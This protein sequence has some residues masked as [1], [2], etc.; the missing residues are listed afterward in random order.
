[1]QEELKT[2][3]PLFFI[4]G[5]GFRNCDKIGYWGR[6]PKVLRKMGSEVYCSH[7]DSNAT[8]EEN[9]NQLVLEMRKVL[10]RT[11]SEKLNIIAHS[12]GGLE[13]R[14]IISTLK[15]GFISS[16]TTLS[17]PHNG[18]KT[19]DAL[20]KIPPI[21][22]KGGSK[23]FDFFYKLAGDKKPDTYNA[24]QIFRTECAAEF[25]RQNPDDPAVFY[26]SCSFVMKNPFSDILLGF[27]YIVVKHFEGENDGLL[28][29]AA[30]KWTNYMGTFSSPHRRGISH[31]DAVD[32]RRRKFAADGDGVRDITNFYVDIV[33][34][35]KEKGF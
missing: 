11:G 7:Q 17:T 10:E 5:M 13:A 20:L 8:V 14:Y 18:S 27:P 22:I 1:M 31:N 21:L 15:C 6:I 26:Q 16:L 33:R 4:H 25:N 24:I 30:C 19:V 35:L 23:I 2:K 34:D 3:Y 12:K 28:T 32:L 9:A 29:P